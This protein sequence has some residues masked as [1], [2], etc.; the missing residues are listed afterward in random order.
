M[1]IFGPDKEC[2]LEKY[3]K[4]F[5]LPKFELLRA[6]ASGERDG[7]EA[8]QKALEFVSLTYSNSEEGKKAAEVLETINKL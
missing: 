2:R 5:I 6:Y 8:F 4:L 3:K 1:D 7:V